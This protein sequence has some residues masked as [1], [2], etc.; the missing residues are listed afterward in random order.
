MFGGFRAFGV[1]ETLS[2]FGRLG[3]LGVSVA[4]RA[5]KVYSTQV[6]LESHGF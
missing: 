2:G 6:D 1:L 4:L 5:L 3:C